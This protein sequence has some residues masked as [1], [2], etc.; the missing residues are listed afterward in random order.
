M[1]GVLE[2]FRTILSP[3]TNF[4]GEV[5]TTLQISTA[6]VLEFLASFLQGIVNVLAGLLSWLH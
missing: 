1:D 3:I 2:F 5:F 4:L 6:Y